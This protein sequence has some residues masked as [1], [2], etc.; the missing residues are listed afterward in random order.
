MA[1][2]R[3][4]VNMLYDLLLRPLTLEKKKEKKNRNILPYSGSRTLL[5]YGFLINVALLVPSKMIHC[6]HSGHNFLSL[7]L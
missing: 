4:N 1:M 7:I 2:E 5:K 3:G 6:A